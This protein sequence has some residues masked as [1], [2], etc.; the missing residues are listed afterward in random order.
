MPTQRNREQACVRNIWH[1]LTSLQ[2]IRRTCS[3]ALDNARIAY[4]S[5]GPWWDKVPAM[6][7]L[8]LNAAKL[9]VTSA[10]PPCSVTD[11]RK[12]VKFNSCVTYSN[13]DVSQSWHGS[14]TCMWA[15][16]R[17]TLGICSVSKLVREL[18]GWRRF[19]AQQC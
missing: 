18:E 15:S 10:A 6:E 14:S 4:L 8:L 16:T 7:E 5:H 12:I 1:H 13:R 9:P 3:S 17:A 19:M 2:V 11:A